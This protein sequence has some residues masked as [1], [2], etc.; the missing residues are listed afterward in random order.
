MSL[1]ESEEERSVRR[2]GNCAL[3]LLLLGVIELLMIGVFMKN[4]GLIIASMISLVS[5]IYMLY[6]IFYT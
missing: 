6:I 4:M 3:F 5:L 1:F 2:L